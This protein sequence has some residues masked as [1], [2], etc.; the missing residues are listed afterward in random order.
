[1]INTGTDDA[2]Y[3]I[4]NQ[5]SVRIG[6]PYIRRL[7]L[8]ISEIDFDNGYISIIQ[9]KTEVPLSLQMPCDVSE[10]LTTHLENDKYSPEDGYVFHSMTAPYGRITT[11]IIRHAIN[12][13]FDTAKVCTEGK[14]HGSHSLRSS[15]ASSMVNDDVS[16]DVVRRILGHTD[17]DVIKHYAKAD[18]EN[19]RLCSIDPPEA[20][21]QFLEFLS[22]KKVICHV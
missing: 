7:R 1:M 11:S 17:P 20:S 9:E 10:A 19:L 18:I 13:C 21:G 14:K 15:L 4:H 6:S 5:S 22:G 3:G 12:E 8:K 2:V 16:Y